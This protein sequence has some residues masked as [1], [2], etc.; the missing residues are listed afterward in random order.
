LYKEGDLAF[1]ANAGVLNAPVTK[2]NYIRF[3]KTTLFDHNSMQ[4]EAQK[5][6]PFDK[7]LGSGIL[8]RMCDELA[9]K[10]FNPKPMTIEDLTIATAGVPGNAVTPLSVSSTGTRNF[11]PKPSSE[12]FDHQVIMTELNGATQLQSSIFGETWS[13]EF[14]QALYDSD[15]VREELAK[16]EL[17]QAWE[18]E[19]YT[20]RLKTAASL[21]S[22][23][24]Y[25]GT[26]REVIFVELGGW[27]HH[28]VSF[29]C[30]KIPSF[31]CLRSRYPISGGQE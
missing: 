1:F 9:A 22:S 29:R 31:V 23:H 7:A 15:K 17:T 8:G 26:D 24:M 14:I 4:K 13:S 2:K 12:N 25:R 21:I 19:G 5:V 27:D 28:E 11:N 18:G 30:L 20:R 6:D 3:T 10:G 16:V